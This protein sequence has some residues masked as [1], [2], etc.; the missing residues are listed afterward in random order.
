V[1]LPELSKEKFGEVYAVVGVVERVGPPEA[2]PA[3]G[4]GPQRFAEA[5]VVVGVLALD[6]VVRPALRG[7][8][9]PQLVVKCTSVFKLS[10]L[11]VIC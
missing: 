4:F 11:F 1:R 2:E 5:V 8:Q 3:T 9:P 7:Q 6:I 10:R